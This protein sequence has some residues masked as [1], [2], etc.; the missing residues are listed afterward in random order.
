MPSK[1]IVV[2]VNL[3]RGPSAWADALAPHGAR[4]LSLVRAFNRQAERQI[5]AVAGRTLAAPLWG[6]IKSAAG[7]LHAIYKREFGLELDILAEVLGTTVPDLIVANSAYDLANGIGCTAFSVGAPAGPIHAR[8]LEWDFPGKLLRRHTTVTRVQGRAGN[9]A[10]VGWPGFFG[11]LTGVAPGRF[12]I[13]V[14]F[15][16]HDLESAAIP[17]ARRAAA[18]FWPVS[19][20]VRLALDEARSFADAVRFLREV[21]LLSP[22]LFLVVG[23]KNFERVV[24]ERSSSRSA[25]R[26]DRGALRLTNHYVTQRFKSSNV[27]LEESD[28]YDRHDVLSRRLR[29]GSCCTPETALDV[30]RHPF[31]YGALT[32]HQVAMSATTGELV[33]RVPGQRAAS[34]D[35]T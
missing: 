31:L 18:G 35:I 4:G 33:V 19:W 17:L 5:G 26:T 11:V 16:Q 20:A 32:Q 12:S 3:Q 24:I 30:L 27:D 14:N 9:Y 15:V 2:D 25:V 13:S 8:N 23:V 6:S 21:Q 10:T 7:A 22:A 1:P 34:I 29:R 28:T